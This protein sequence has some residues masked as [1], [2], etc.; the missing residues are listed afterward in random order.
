MYITG[1]IHPIDPPD[2]S[3]RCYGFGA[4][5]FA[6]LS[7]TM[8]TVLADAATGIKW[9]KTFGWGIGDYHRCLYYHG[10]IIY[11]LRYWNLYTNYYYYYIIIVVIIV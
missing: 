1:V 7:H 3:P 10:N 9:K 8:T 4:L 2:E 6:L 5:S 11:F